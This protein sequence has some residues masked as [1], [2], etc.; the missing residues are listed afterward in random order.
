VSDLRA[1]SVIFSEPRPPSRLA[2]K[3]GT[4]V[5]LPQDEYPISRRWAR[6]KFDL[7]VSVITLGPTKGAS[8]HGRGSELNCGGMTLYVEIELCVGDQV[9]IQLTP[10]HSGQPI[11]VRGFVR[12]ACGGTYGIEFITENDADYGSVGQIESLLRNIPV[13]P[14]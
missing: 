8:V 1:T 3:Y 14:L 13:S 12:N 7:P 9:G 4:E 6:H 2:H 11:T 10:T 5:V